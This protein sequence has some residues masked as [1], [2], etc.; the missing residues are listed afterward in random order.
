MA[1]QTL[2]ALKFTESEAE[3]KH[4]VVEAIKLVAKRLGNTPA[5]CRKHYIH[6]AVISA[7]LS[8]KLESQAPAGGDLSAHEGALLRLLKLAG[9]ARG[10][11]C[12]SDCEV[13]T[14]SLRAALNYR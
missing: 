4:G 11:G 1:A 2:S 8:G 5:T 6:P 10:R 12:R 13:R 14:G 7:F 9:S 3:M